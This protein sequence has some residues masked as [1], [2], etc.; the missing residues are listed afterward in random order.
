MLDAT[1]IFW[2]FA[3]AIVIIALATIFLKGKL[4][5]FIGLILSIYTSIAGF[6]LLGIE[7]GTGSL[8]YAPHLLIIGGMILSCKYLNSLLTF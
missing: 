6:A 8:F 4:L 1:I 5:N 2:G 3:G 7:W